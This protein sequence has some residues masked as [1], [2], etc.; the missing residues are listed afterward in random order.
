LREIEFGP[1][2]V[3][4]GDKKFREEVQKFVRETLEPK[5]N[6]R[7]KARLSD[8]NRPPWFGW[9]QQVAVLSL[10]HNVKPPGPPELWKKLA[11]RNKPR[12]PPM[13]D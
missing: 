12:M 6:P 7:E 10:K 5:L 13:P 3:Q 8:L 9:F 11:E 2:G 4:I 1:T